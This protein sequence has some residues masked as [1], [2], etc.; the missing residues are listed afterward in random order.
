MSAFVKN[1]NNL[2]MHVFIMALE[3]ISQHTNLITNF[4]TD[5]NGFVLEFK[6]TKKLDES[7]LNQ[8]QKNVSKII[9]NNFSIQTIKTCSLNP[10]LTKIYQNNPQK[11]HFIQIKSYQNL[12]LPFA[13][14]LK[15]IKHF[16]L[17][18]FKQKKANTYQLKAIAFSD[19]KTYLAYLELKTKNKEHDHR[20]LGKEL[21]LFAF[22]EAIGQGLPLWL[23]KGEI[24]KNRIKT[25]LSS[26]F[27][28]A[29]FQF[30]NTPILGS[31]Q[32][33]VQS[34][35]WQHYQQNNYPPIT[36]D[37]ET[38]M[39][40]P[41][42][43]PHHI[44]IYNLKPR[45]YKQLP[46]YL[47]EDSKLFRYEASG[48]LFGLE[49]VRSMEL[50]DCHII[51]T[52]QQIQTIILHLATLLTKIHQKLNLQIHQIDLSLKDDQKNKYHDDPQMWEL[53]E[54]ELKTI[55]QKL[56]FTITEKKG[57]AAFYGPKI[58]YQVKNNLNKIITISTIQLDFL[59]PKRFQMFYFDQNNQKQ[60]VVLIHFGPVGTYERLIATILSQ[61]K[62]YLPL[63]LAP[64]QFV[65]IPVNEKIADNE[66]QKLATFLTKNNLTAI[67]DN[68]KERFNKKIR[69]AQMA[70]IPYQ[71]ILGMNEITNNIIT[72][73]RSYD[74]K[75]QS[76]SYAE[77]INKINFELTN[78]N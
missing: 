39:L 50:F 44:S 51:T 55:L 9:A 33:Y 42:T 69:N 24:M 8:L 58:D 29:N 52:Y 54:K 15:D 18:A 72:Y 63:W 70:K 20:K 78:E 25:F 11:Y 61:T 26:L 10:F 71:L 23:P 12:S 32:L 37:N 28:Q 21:E 34:G 66:C 38:Y 76:S 45:T 36:I 64:I 2:A 31:K 62:G 3:A 48:G 30:V 68:S 41:M 46:F 35:H 1:I 5:D 14:K 19:Q 4:T 6:T 67:I 40:R 75:T 43:C 77:F 16:D 49:R 13:G 22:S 73:R 47:C 57:E 56:A 7:A 17:I 59:L 60:P 27:L 74:Q 65:I 53:A